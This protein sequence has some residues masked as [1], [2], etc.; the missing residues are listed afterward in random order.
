[1]PPEWDGT[2]QVYPDRHAGH[3]QM[4][5]TESCARCHGTGVRVHVDEDW[6]GDVY[7][8]DYDEVYC[9]CPCGQLKQR[10]E[11]SDAP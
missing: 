10:L 6:N 1:M 11:R 3:R 7:N 8:C 9:A 2:G 5:P 4:G